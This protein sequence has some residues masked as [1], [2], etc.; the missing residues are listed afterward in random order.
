M[1]R[2]LSG[3]PSLSRQLDDLWGDS[4]EGEEAEAASTPFRS[5]FVVGHRLPGSAKEDLLVHLSP[6]PAP[7]EEEDDEEDGEQ[8]APSVD[9]PKSVDEVDVEW[10][11][12]HHSQMERM[13]P[14]GI[15][16]IG[17]FFVSDQSGEEALRAL[18]R[19]RKVLKVVSGRARAKTK[20]QQQQDFAVLHLSRSS[21]QVSAR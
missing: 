15:D 11:L 2:A 1:V 20:Q 7:D 10:M 3:S 8:K 19:L 13:L 6:T 5:G 18:G 9:P 14:G 17:V 4:A 12:E 21:K 16:V